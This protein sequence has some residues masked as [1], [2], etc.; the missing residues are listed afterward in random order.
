MW[1]NFYASGGW[2]MHPVAVFGFFMIVGAVLYALRPESRYQRLVVAFGAL[3]FASG[4]LASATGICTSA[5]YIQEVEPAKQL[6]ILSLGI[7]ESMHGIVLACML[8]VLGG[9]LALVGV[10]RSPNAPLAR[11]A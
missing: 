1:S 6:G 11:A 7:E 2:G 5:H 3:T 10:L 9:L 8:V 4:V